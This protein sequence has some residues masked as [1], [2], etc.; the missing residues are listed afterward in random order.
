M[1]T[2]KWNVQIRKCR[3][4]LSKMYAIFNSTQLNKPPTKKVKGGHIPNS[5]INSQF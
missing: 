1:H 2:R 5:Q 4:D 3:P